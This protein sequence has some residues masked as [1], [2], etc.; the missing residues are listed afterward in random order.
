MGKLEKENEV[1][2]TDE[3]TLVLDKIDKERNI[4]AKSKVLKLSNLSNKMTTVQ[5]AIFSLLK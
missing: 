5:N 4:L 2:N 1:L 3:N